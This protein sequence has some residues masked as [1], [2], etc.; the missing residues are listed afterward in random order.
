MPLHFTNSILGDAIAL[1]AAAADISLDNHVLSI[2]TCP[3]MDYRKIESIG[4]GWVA[5]QAETLG[6]QTV[7]NAGTNNTAY[8]FRITQFVASLGRYVI[9]DI[10]HQSPTAG[11]TTTTVSNA[12]RAELRALKD[13]AV[14]VNADGN[15]TAVITAETGSPIL[16]I[17][18][19]SGTTT[20][21]TT[22]GVHS[23]G[24]YADLI[25]AG[26]TN[27]VAGETYKQIAFDYTQVSPAL[28]L[29]SKEETINRHTLYVNEADAAFADF[30]TRME[31][32][33]AAYATGGTDADPEAI[34]L[35]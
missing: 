9:H 20:V 2:T 31:E 21:N 4:A 16:S 1:Q 8:R 17:V 10:T 33:I 7:S 26:V 5:S 3:S 28:L 23:R 34:S 19:V 35:G 12:F 24:T 22:P 11:T 6:V 14:T 27:A 30:D 29:G 13:L 15:A 32:V 18:D 25:L